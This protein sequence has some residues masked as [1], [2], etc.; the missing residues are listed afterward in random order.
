MVN[1]R[2]EKYA[3]FSD[4][5]R[6]IPDGWHNLRSCNFLVGE[7]STGKS[8]FIQLV[9]LIDSRAHMA[10]LDVLGVVTGIET[11]S[12]VCS[13]ASRATSTTIG[14]LI[15][16]RD[17]E[18]RQ[19]E[20]SSFGRLATYKKIGDD[21]QLIRLTVFADNEVVRLKLVGNQLR[22]KSDKFQYLDDLSHSENGARLSEFHRAAGVRFKRFSDD[23]DASADGGSSVW[24]E[25]IRSAAQNPS[26]MLSSLYGRVAPLNCVHYGPMRSKFR[27]LYYGIRREFSSTGEHFAFVM[28]HAATQSAKVLSSV[29]QFGSE[30][31]LFDKISITPVRTP[32]NDRPFAFQ[33]ERSG[34]FFYVDELGYGVGQILPIVGDIAYAPHDV[35]FLIE[36]PELHL[37]P[38][39][40]AALGNIFYEKAVTGGALVIET[41]SDFIIDRFRMAAKSKEGDARFQIMYFDKDG[42][43]RNRCSEIE[44]LPDGSLTDVPDGYRQFFVNEGIDKFE[45][46]Q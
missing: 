30:S 46:L 5:F 10:F 18:G 2:I 35:S 14:F 15:K 39:A 11:A 37:H 17:S 27:R 22:Y 21:L 16:E 38:K 40:Q 4:G 45:A 29:E 44:I 33:V 20:R 9:E 32:V 42:Q 34:S 6:G 19:R 1:K 41:H 43:G 3:I 12:D 8:S 13:R 7:N 24:L 28:R 36:Q 25:A 23:F 31:G 26:K